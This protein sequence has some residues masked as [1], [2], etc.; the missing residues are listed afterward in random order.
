[1][2]TTIS[3][4]QMVLWIGIKPKEKITKGVSFKLLPKNLRRVFVSK[5]V[6]NNWIV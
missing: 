2:S 6:V 1:M 5:P 3:T 4:G